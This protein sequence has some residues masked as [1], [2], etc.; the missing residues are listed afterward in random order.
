MERATGPPSRWKEAR[1]Y[2][3]TIKTVRRFQA[4]ESMRADLPDVS[5]TVKL[6]LHETAFALD[7]AIG[8]NFGNGQVYGRLL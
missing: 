4:L 2:V 8:G 6:S 7:G 3:N 5:P 1:R